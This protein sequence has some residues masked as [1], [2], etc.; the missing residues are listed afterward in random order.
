VAAPRIW[1]TFGILRPCGEAKE[2]ADNSRPAVT[3]GVTTG[4]ES[5]IGT[6]WSFVLFS[7]EV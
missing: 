2:Q 4:R 6:G 7:E 3:I 5:S 1:A